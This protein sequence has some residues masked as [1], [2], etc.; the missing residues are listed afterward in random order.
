MLLLALTAACGGGQV[1]S[2]AQ[3]AA[4][5]RSASHLV[6]QEAADGR[7]TGPYVHAESEELAQAA[8]SLAVQ[9]RSDSGDPAARDRALRDAQAARDGMS[10]L[11]AHP[12]DRAVAAA[13]ARSLAEPSP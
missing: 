8:A 10:R 12:D 9:L 6:A 7:L 2:D 1:S 13:V 3:Q 5:L 11:A 4:S